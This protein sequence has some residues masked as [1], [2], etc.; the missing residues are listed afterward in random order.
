MGKAAVFVSLTEAA[1]RLGIGYS[2][3]R[4]RLL[5]GELDGKRDGAHWV[6]RESSL[7][8]SLD[9]QPAA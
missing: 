8:A 5:R 3:A 4:D 7:E 9:T 1:I 2:V 6:V